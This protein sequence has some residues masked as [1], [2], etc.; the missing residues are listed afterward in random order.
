VSLSICDWKYGKEWVYSITYD[1]ALVELHRFAVPCHEEFGIPGHVEAVAGHLG[2]VRRL[3]QSSYNG[4]RHMGPA[5]LRELVARGWGV[6]NHSWSHERIAPDMVARELGEAKERLE[7]A[8]GARV[9]LYCAPGD[10]GN[11]SEHVLAACREYG[12]LG[13]MS[14]TD[15]L[16]LPGEPLFWLNRTPLHDQYYGPFFSAFDP[17]RNLRHAQAERGWIIDYC[18][19]PLEEPVHRNKDC[20]AAQLRRRFEAV[21]SEGGSSA[22]W[23]ANP[24]EVI[25]YH[26]TRRHA[27]VATVRE[28][29]REH[30]YLLTLEGLPPDVACRTLTLE[31]EVPA[32]WCRDPRVWIDG[33]PRPAELVHPRRL[34]VTA[35]IGSRMEIAFRPVPLPSR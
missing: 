11:M 24:D 7:E 20:S 2:E 16:N 26:L 9:A 13:A 1:E 28:T 34:Q 23:C 14:I 6:G 29:D 10:N 30:G 31:A 22:V 17:Y 5:E 25:D 32:A 12:Y 19:C 27:R 15:A 3:G 21:L 8:V 33:Q 4:F 35:E 18:H